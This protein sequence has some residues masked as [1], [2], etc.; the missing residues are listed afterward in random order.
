MNASEQPKNETESGPEEVKAQRSAGQSSEA[1]REVP[2]FLR[3]GSDGH[4]GNA[5]DEKDEIGE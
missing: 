4:K 2:L 5:Q 3:K 1:S